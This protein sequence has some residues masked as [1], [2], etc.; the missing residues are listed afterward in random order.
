MNA[1][2]AWLVSVA[3]LL[4]GGGAS[5]PHTTVTQ[6]A[7]VAASRTVV[8]TATTSVPAG[9]IATTSHHN[10]NPAAPLREPVIETQPSITPGIT[11]AALT[12][13]LADFESRI[14]NTIKGIPAAPT[15]AN[16][17]Q[18]VAA[19]GYYAGSF[20]SASQNI[21]QLANTAMTS[22]TITGGSITGTTLS[23]V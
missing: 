11:S 20:P 21:G 16:V 18:Y 9:L 23:G 14:T 6:T 4:F 22:P 19:Q 13:I 17:P 5:A 7:A 12:S 8:P 2:V 1:I 3:M 15:Y 10:P